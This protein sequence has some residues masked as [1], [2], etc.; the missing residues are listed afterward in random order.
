MRLGLIAR[1]DNSGL[2]TLS[3]EFARHLRPD[4]VLLVENG[5]HQTFPE[6]FSGFDTRRVLTGIQGMTREWLLDV[7]V[8]LSFETFYDWSLI[9]D[10][11]KRGVKTALYT[12][13]EMTPERIPLHPDLYLCPSRID[14]DVMPKP[15]VY[16]PTP[17]ATDRL[18]WKERTIATRFIHTASHG[19]VSGRKGTQ[20]LIDAWSMVTG[21]VPLT[22]YTWKPFTTNDSRISIEVVNFR[23]YWQVWREGDVLVYPQ[24]YNG[25]SLPVAEA[26]ASGL[27]V[28]TTDIYPFNEYLP[29]ELLFEHGG[30]YRTRAAPILME[31]DAVKIVP[32]K[33]AEKVNEW[34]GKDISRFSASGRVWAEENS[35]GKLLPEFN[36]VLG[37]LAM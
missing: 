4:K 7:D 16:L 21:D 3:W 31:V 17:V 23:N 29:K 12:M 32:E 24:D 28:I 34:A 5:V 9:K 11:R 35:W 25:I 2:G 15:K 10:T 13:Y 33:I 8:L 37:N 20:K 26:F 19:G 36:R 6:R 1:Y 18:R 22:I 27:G 30:A 14:Y